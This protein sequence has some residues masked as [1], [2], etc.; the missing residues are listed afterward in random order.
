MNE[1]KFI[2]IGIAALVIVAIILWFTHMPNVLED[3]DMDIIIAL[4]VGLL[5]L[6]VDKRQERHLQEISINQ[7]EM[8]NDIHN[9]IKEH[10]N[11][12]TEMHMKD[13]EEKNKN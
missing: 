10:I 7:H 4:S 2:L 13:K 9:I 11:I 1:I 3:K 6:F 8:I 12:L 5:I